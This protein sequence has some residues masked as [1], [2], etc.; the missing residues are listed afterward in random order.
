MKR[1]D[2]PLLAAL[3]AVAAPAP[4]QDEPICADRPGVGTPPCVTERGRV[5]AELGAV[6]WT[7]DREGGARTDTIVAGDV[8]TRIGIGG[9]TELQLGWTAF[10]HVRGRMDGAVESVSGIG[11]VTVGVL[12]GVVDGDGVALSVLGRA[13]LPLGGAAIGAGDWSASLLVPVEVDLG[14]PLSLGLTPSIAA[15]VDQDRRGRHLA[16]GLVTGLTADFE[17]HLF[18][19]ELA[20]DRDDDPAGQG[21]PMV[22]AFSGGWRPDPNLQFDAG[23]NLGLNDD[24][25]DL[26]LYVGLSKRF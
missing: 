26:Q 11:D 22:L 18:G 5:V 9:G 21:T 12:K 17:T 6:S 25:D 19:I 16:Y 1:R 7:L 20:V 4:A 2:L 24:A 3:T 10:G 8:L 15:E 14:G 13:T 23:T